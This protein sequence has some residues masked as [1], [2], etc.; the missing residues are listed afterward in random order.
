MLCSNSA[1]RIS[2]ASIRCSPI[3]FGTATAASA[4]TSSLPAGP[5]GATRANNGQRATAAAAPARS[6]STLN[7]AP[8]STHSSSGNDSRCE[9]SRSYRPWSMVA[10]PSRSLTPCAL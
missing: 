8:A 2:R 7:G 6:T 5:L 3:G 4:S 1:G 10:P 9:T